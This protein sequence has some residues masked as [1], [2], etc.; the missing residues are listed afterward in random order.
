MRLA[1]FCPLE[2]QRERYFADFNRSCSDRVLALALSFL[3]APAVSNA[4]A[5]YLVGQQATTG[6]IAG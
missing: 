6:R 1:Y 3:I 4:A 2:L 5:D